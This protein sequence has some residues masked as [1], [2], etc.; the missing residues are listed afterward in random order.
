MNLTTITAVRNDD[1]TVTLTDGSTLEGRFF[2]VNSKGLNVTVDGRLVTRA[3][4]KIESVELT[5]DLEVEDEGTDEVEVDTEDG[6]TTAD[7]ADMFEVST[8]ALRRRL[9][10]MGMGVGKGHRYSFDDDTLDSIKRAI[11][12]API[13]A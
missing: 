3:A 12:G 6:Y 11:E 1:I 4:S 8:R 10:D 7:L 2:S 13:E 5:A 9:R